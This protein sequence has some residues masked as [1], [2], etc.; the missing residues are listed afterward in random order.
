MTASLILCLLTTALAQDLP[1]DSP[2]EPL[3]EVPEPLPEVLE[4]PPEPPNPNACRGSAIFP[5]PDWSDV[6]AQIRSER[7][8]AVAALEEYAFSPDLDRADPER[9]GVRTDGVVI[10][11]GGRIIYERYGGP[12]GPDTLHLAWSMSKTLV[13]LYAGIAV[14]D[15]SLTL[16]S[17]ACDAV[18]GLPETSCAVHLDHLLQFSSGF[19]WLET[20]EGQSPVASSVLAMLYGQGQDGMG[21]FVAGHAARDAPGSTY[22]YS[23]GDTNVITRMLDEAWRPE[24]GERWPHAR[25]F[26]PL[27]MP[28]AVFERDRSGVI[29]GSSWWWSTPRDM[30]RV[31]LLL[32]EDGC[33]QGERLV[34][35]GWIGSMSSM[36]DAIQQAA[37]DRSGSD[38]QGRQLWLNQQV[39]SQGMVRRPWPHVP[40]DAVAA[41]GHWKQS[42]TVIPSL[43]LVVVRTGDDRDGSFSPDRFLSLSIAVSGQGPILEPGDFDAPDNPPSAL[44]PNRERKYDTGLL[45]IA[46]GFAAKEGC[47]CAFVAGLD[48]DTCREWLKVSPDVAKMRFDHDEKAVRARAL[49]MARRSAVYV[50][51]EQGCRL[52]P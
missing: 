9:R 40:D 37:W 17:S 6:S 27:G 43:D 36:N 14:G 49:G 15:G 8:E 34:P 35:P 21:A 1:T 39:D 51:A 47:S 4:L 33:W 23:S 10:V 25:L 3:P 41:M 5:A 29:V 44:A 19:D 31:G 45:R 12:Y 32:R 38:V 7:P 22:M 50:N 26:E 42:I 20:Y 13:G 11:H 52:E 24:H 30:A 2:P 46:T 28:R 48:D 16:D 18:A